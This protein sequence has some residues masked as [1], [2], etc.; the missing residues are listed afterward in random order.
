MARVQ[1]I[2][3]SDNSLKAQ[4]INKFISGDYNGAFAIVDNNPQLVSKA[5]VAEVVNNIVN[6]LLGLENNYFTNVPNYLSDLTITFQD[7]IDEFKNSETWSSSITYQRYNFV[8]YNNE[9]YMYI[10]ET[11][12]SGNLPTN[13]IYWALIGLRG[14]QGAPGAGINLRYQ[15]NMNVQYNPLDFVYYNGSA[16]IANQTN[17]DQVPAVGSDYWTFFV[18]MKKAEIL[19]SETA[20]T[21]P[22]LGEMWFEMSAT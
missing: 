18:Y 13:T 8:F 5:F 21:E 22:Y 3:I 1:D 12:T 7:L 10:N 9:V 14:A 20:P 19:T 15:W 11:A 17:I 16:W 4:F 2:Q 6:L